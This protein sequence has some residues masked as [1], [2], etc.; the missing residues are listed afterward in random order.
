MKYAQYD[1]LDLRGKLRCPSEL[2][3]AGGAGRGH[4]GL[5]SN[6]GHL[7]YVDF[8]FLNPGLIKAKA[9]LTG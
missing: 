5:V 2:H 9:D 4:R 1:L 3:R 6:R 8:L 7:D